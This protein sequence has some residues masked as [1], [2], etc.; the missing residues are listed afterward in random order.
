M[1]KLFLAATL[2]L[3]SIGIVRAQSR[4][5][6]RLDANFVG[7]NMTTKIGSVS[8]TGSMLAGFRVG[9]AAEFA[10][11]QDGFYIAPGV[12]YTM[13]GAKEDAATC[14]LHY[15]QVPIN[16]GFRA[17]FAQD[18]TVSLEVGPYLA[19]GVAGNTT[20]KNSDLSV[21]AFG[22]KGALKR[23]DMGLGIAAALGYQRYYFQV[24][25][26]H[27]I[28]NV[29]QKGSSDFSIRNYDFFVGVGVR[30]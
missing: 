27:G 25:Y 5:T 26:D 4:P 28:L 20:L 10:I 15:L 17:S 16:A 9:G 3:A 2:V 11:G 24:G 7:S 8:A 19:Y 6:F 22:D 23:F 21:D 18:M 14:R 30:F 29:A 12:A 1:K 13:K